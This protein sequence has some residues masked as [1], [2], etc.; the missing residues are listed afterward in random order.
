MKILTLRQP[1]AWAVLSPIANKDVE[2]RFWPTK[3]RGPV[4]IHAAK[5]MTKRE[6]EIAK[7]FMLGIGVPLV[8]NP[9]EMYFG[10]I[11]GVVEIVDCVQ[12]SPSLWYEGAEV[13]GK[14]NYGFVLRNATPLS[15]P[16]PHKGM[17]SFWTP[18]NVNINNLLEETWQNRLQK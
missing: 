3:Y 11:L 13:F 2:N 5:G 12:D 9:D 6:F 1:W 16:I 7:N 4:G 18:K 14:N 15:H 17:L 8:P 10:H